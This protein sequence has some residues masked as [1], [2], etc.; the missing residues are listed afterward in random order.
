MIER[1]GKRTNFE[2]APTDAAAANAA[3]WCLGGNRP[4][5]AVNTD[6]N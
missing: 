4:C 3:E 6:I 1:V 2:A 5:T